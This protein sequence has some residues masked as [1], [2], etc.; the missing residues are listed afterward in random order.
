GVLYRQPK[1]SVQFFEC[2]NFFP[3][4]DK[5]VLI[6]SAYKP[7]RYIIGSFNAETYTFTPEKESTLD[8]GSFY[9]SNI[10]V[11]QKTEPIILVG[12]VRG[13]KEGL[14]WNGCMSSPRRLWIGSDGYLRQFPMLTSLPVKKRG[15]IQKISENESL[16]ESL[17]RSEVGD[18][19][20]IEWLNG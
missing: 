19:F 18:T 14:G 5:W 3:L 6:Y 9:A 13:F 1:T 2:P 17:A 11:D 15:R 20:M 8:Y 4:D 16:V 12:W 10:S 7:L